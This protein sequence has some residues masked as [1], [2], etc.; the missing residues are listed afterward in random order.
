[1]FSDMKSE[2]PTYA[3]EKKYAFLC[4]VIFF[5]IFFSNFFAGR[6]RKIKRCAIDARGQTG[7]WFQLAASSWQKW[8]FYCWKRGF[9]SK[10][11]PMFILFVQIVSPEGASIPLGHRTVTN[12]TATEPSNKYV[13]YDGADQV[14][15][16]SS[17]TAK[18]SSS[19]GDSVLSK[20]QLKCPINNFTWI[21]LTLPPLQ[22]THTPDYWSKIEISSNRNDPNLLSLTFLSS[23]NFWLSQPHRNL[24]TEHN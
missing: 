24:Q 4:Q 2:C 17:D 16:T 20:I 13:V 21:I 6:I 1:M 3:S 23:P 15:I 14:I 7:R 10:I 9:W 19:D 11:N 12:Q 5:E 8:L 22:N 18:N